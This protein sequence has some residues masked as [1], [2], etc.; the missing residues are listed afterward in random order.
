MRSVNSCRV[1]FEA[2]HLPDAATLLIAN[3]LR[4]DRTLGLTSSLLLAISQ[5]TLRTPG[6]AI[7]GLAEQ[8]RLTEKP[9]D[10]PAPGK[11]GP[12][13]QLLAAGIAREDA[14]QPDSWY[15]REYRRSENRKYLFRDSR[16]KFLT[17]FFPRLRVMP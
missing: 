10:C 11:T 3:S 8:R 1:I 9:F 4:A 14:S 7:P 16:D 17:F 6:R 13:H 15:L 5:F 12:Y 2:A